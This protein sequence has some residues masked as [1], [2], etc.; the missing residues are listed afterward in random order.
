M[1][2]RKEREKIELKNYFF[3]KNLKKYQNTL[4]SGMSCFKKNKENGK[5]E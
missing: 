3:Y 2:N 5:K 4:W 1:R